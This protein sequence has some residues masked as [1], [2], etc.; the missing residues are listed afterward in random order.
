MNQSIKFNKTEF[1]YNNSNTFLHNKNVIEASEISA[2]WMVDHDWLE[3][4]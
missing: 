2:G 1:Y 3:V 4:I